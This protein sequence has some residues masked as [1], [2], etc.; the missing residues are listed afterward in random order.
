MYLED[1]GVLWAI[2]ENVNHIE[3][4]LGL[5]YTINNIEETE[6]IIIPR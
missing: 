1:I 3:T 6:K 2:E 5:L 4:V